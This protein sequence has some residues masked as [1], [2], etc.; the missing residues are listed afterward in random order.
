MSGATAPR[1][2]QARPRRASGVRGQTRAE[3]EAECAVATEIY[4]RAL[5][6]KGYHAQAVAE[7]RLPPTA[8]TPAERRRQLDFFV[9]DPDDVAALLNAYVDETGVNRLDVMAQIPG[10]ESDGRQALAVVDL[11]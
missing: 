2:A 3:A 5:G 11:I 6:N 1:A 7:G 4:F 10:L 8:S 9:G